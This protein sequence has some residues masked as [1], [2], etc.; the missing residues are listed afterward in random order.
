MTF[1]TK[2]YRLEHELREHKKVR[3]GEKLTFVKK[4]SHGNIAW[5]PIYMYV[6]TLERGHLVCDICGKAFSKKNSVSSHT[7]ILVCHTRIHT[8][9]ETVCLWNLWKTDLSSHQRVHTGKKPFLQ[10]CGHN[11]FSR[12]D[13]YLWPSIWSN[14]LRERST[15]NILLKTL[16]DLSHLNAEW[17][18][19]KESTLN[20][21]SLFVTFVE[22]TNCKSELS[23]HQ[24]VHTL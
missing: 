20:K 15:G 22:K 13:I 5:L 10:T 16:K 6:F 17:E 21:D 8:W 4:P 12:E 18:S 9:R 2:C 19:T 23:A 14:L 3:T 11:S 7:G 24:C 1:V